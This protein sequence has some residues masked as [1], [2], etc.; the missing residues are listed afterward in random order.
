[1]A[2]YLPTGSQQKF[3]GKL[4]AT[5]AYN[6]FVPMVAADAL[7]LMSL[8]ITPSTEFHEIK[9]RRGSASLSGEVKGK[10]GG[11]WSAMAYI[12][13]EGTTITTMPDIGDLLHA[14]F[15]EQNTSGDVSYFLH[16]SNVEHFAPQS[17]Q[18][19]RR[20]GPYHYESIAGCWVES[21]EFDI[22]TEIPTVSFSG[23]YSSRAYAYGALVNNGSGIVADATTVE[24]D[25]GQAE[26]FAAGSYIQFNDGGTIKNGG[27]TAGYEITGV[28]TTTDVLTISPAIHSVAD[29]PISDNSVIEGLDLTQTL[30]TNDPVSGVGSE[31]KIGTYS[32]EVAQGFISFKVTMA[33]GIKGLSDEASSAVATRL[34]LG[35]RRITGE[36]SCYALSS[37]TTTLDIMSHIGNGPNGTPVSLICRAGVGTSQARCVLNVPAARL[38][39]VPIEVPEAEEAIVTCSFTAQRRAADGD[40]FHIDFS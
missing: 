24:L 26:K 27:G 10:E 19:V 35:E 12:K 13:P 3:W 36:F 23:G 32:G 30:T 34:I 1:M 25:A 6:T 18:F 39:V 7:P 2:T 33:T 21:V 20:A 29:A 14:A 4:E 11:T 37:S 16:T 40:E 28:N 38:D 8:E 15:G 5:D 17:L 31:F 22:N 9:E